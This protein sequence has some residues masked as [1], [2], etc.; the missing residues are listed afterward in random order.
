MKLIKAIVLTSISIAILGAC[1]TTTTLQFTSS[2]TPDVITH[3]P[4]ESTIHTFVKANRSLLLEEA[5][6]GQGTHLDT[7]AHV[8]GCSGKQKEDFT[9][10]IQ[11]NYTQ[12]FHQTSDVEISKS[13]LSHR[14]L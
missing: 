1:E 13:L 12:I 11:G 4:A 7:V 3:H 8:L 14:C 6:Q 10:T 5:A 9:A 2:S